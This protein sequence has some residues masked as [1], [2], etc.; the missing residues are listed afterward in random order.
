MLAQS[1]MV[2]DWLS[3]AIS[4][5]LGNLVEKKPRGPIIPIEFGKFVALP[6]FLRAVVSLL[7]P[8]RMASLRAAGRYPCSVFIAAAYAWRRSRGKPEIYEILYH[9]DVKENLGGEAA[10][11]T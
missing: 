10:P 11:Q 3:N 1:S 5:I 7:L 4:P 6:A 8:Y 9:E 2:L